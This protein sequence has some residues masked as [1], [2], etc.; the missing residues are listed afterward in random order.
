MLEQL[1]LNSNYGSIFLF[2]IISF[3][4]YFII[5]YFIKKILPPDIFFKGS[6]LKIISSLKVPI[7]LM[8]PPICIKMVGSLDFIPEKLMPV[9]EN[10][11]NI[12]FIGA[13]SLLAIGIVNIL[14][15]FIISK[16]DIT[17]KDNLKARTIHTQVEVIQKIL[18][19]FI[20]IVSISCIL[21]TFD[22]IKQL[23]VSILASAG[24]VGII[25]GFAAQKSIAT[26]F[27]GLQIA[28]TQ[29]IRL[30]D[31]VIVENEWGWIEDITLTYVVVRIWDLRRLVLPITYFIERPFQNWTRVS[32]DLLG[33]VF[34]YA[35]YTVPIEEIRQE[36]KRILDSTP[37]WD[38]KAWCLQVTDSLKDTVE[39]RALMSSKD[40]SIGWDLRCL[41][42]E[43]LIVYLQKNFPDSL[44]RTRINLNNEPKT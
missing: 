22:K 32:A 12:W 20:I 3:L 11:I 10:S 18:I 8:I 15:E 30:E 29:P 31:V 43:Q 35:D 38:Q 40:A 21:M 26:L 24:V 7:A 14:E 27:A 9:V 5:F 39:L 19:I 41:V 13:L 17:K 28:L 6:S 44:P 25:I 4:L 23:G 36:L 2:L 33:T 1:H 42:R 37:L 16:Y 34:I